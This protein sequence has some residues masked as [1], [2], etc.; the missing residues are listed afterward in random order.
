MLWVYGHY[1][2]FHSYSAG[3]NSRRQNLT[4]RVAPRAVRVFLKTK[5]VFEHQDLHMFDLKLNNYA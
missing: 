5:C 4:S 1:K 3:I 2:Y